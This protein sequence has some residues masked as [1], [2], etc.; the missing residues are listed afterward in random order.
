[1]NERAGDKRIVED[2]LKLMERGQKLCSKNS[3]SRLDGIRM[4]K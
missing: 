1:M 4:K 3:N 2:K